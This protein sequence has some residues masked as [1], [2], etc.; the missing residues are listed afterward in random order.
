MKKIYA[1]KVYKNSI[2]N[3]IC[4]KDFITK[5]V[6]IEL[7]KG[8]KSFRKIPSKIPLVFLWFSPVR[9]TP[10]SH[11]SVTFVTYNIFNYNIILLI[12]L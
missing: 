11:P 1:T 5:I 2:K 9:I 6:S 8:K 10:R 7:K 4:Y 12:Y 3:T